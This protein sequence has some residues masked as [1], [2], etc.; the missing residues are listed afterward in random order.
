MINITVRKPDV[1][2]TKQMNPEMSNIYNK[3]KKMLKE[4]IKSDT[5][6]E[7]ENKAD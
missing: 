1:T 5:C 2:I 4:L 3:A 7:G 6:E